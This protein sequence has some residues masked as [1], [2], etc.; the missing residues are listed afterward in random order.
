MALRGLMPAMITPFDA[1]GRLNLGIIPELVEFYRSH[2]MTGLTVGGTNG[3]GTS[4]S[5]GE[6]NSLV[7]EVMKFKGD[8]TI[9]AG[10]GAASV[11]DAETLTRH[12]SDA[13][14]DAVLTLPPFFYK[15]VSALGVANYFRQ[16]LKASKVPVLL[17]SIPQ[18]TGVSITDEI[19]TTLSDE[20]LLAGLKD[21]RGVWEDT[22]Q[23]LER[24]PGLQI[25]TGSDELMAR[26]LIH[27]AAGCISG[28]ANPFPDLVAAV[29]NAHS[30][31]I[32]DKLDVAQA[33]LDVAKT[34]LLKY[35][36]IANNKAVMK[37]RGLPEMFV[38]PPLVNLTNEQRASITTE[39]KEANLI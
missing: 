1:N 15:N 26:G 9:V 20:P 33:R 14:V 11:V 3:E 39:M 19:L 21:S 35:P 16:V 36:L 2:G 7:T 32:D 34:I 28:T 29:G 12:A 22:R 37:L 24:W 13:G 38:R 5:V 10:T 6:R 25:F 8:L 30:S 31:Q 4:M 17:Y 23:L 18:H 27:G